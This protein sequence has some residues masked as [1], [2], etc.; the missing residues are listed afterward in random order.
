MAQ[1]YHYIAPLLLAL[2]TN[3]PVPTQSLYMQVLPMV[4]STA[5]QDMPLEH[6]FK[7]CEY[8][9]QYLFQYGLATSPL[10]NQLC[11]TQQ[12]VALLSALRGALTFEKVN[13]WLG[14]Q[15]EEEQTDDSSPDMLWDQQEIQTEIPIA[16]QLKEIFVQQEQHTL[17]QIHRAILTC[18][19]SFFEE[20]VVELLVKVGYGHSVL[21]V[22]K[23][24]GKSKDGGID[25]VIQEDVFG[26]N[27]VYIQ[28]KRWDTAYTVGRPEIQK[29]VGALEMTRSHKGVYVTTS[30][31]T[32][33][34]KDYV[35]NIS[36]KH[37][38][39]IDGQDFVRLMYDYDVGL[40]EQAVYKI[41]T[42]K[43]E[44]FPQIQTGVTL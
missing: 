23:V 26:F 21:A 10:E 34:A 18:D 27:T 41:K 31:Y 9:T 36:G 30:S 2:N 13:D 44:Y 29:F 37:I 19:P 28:A 40:E 15:V 20:L 32:K 16:A 4:Q 25:G 5:Q 35:A 22:G 24:L 39:L 17:Q 43:D 33:E 6:F 1:Y 38:I 12:G 8:A 11:L 7:Q 42:L 14:I 3:E